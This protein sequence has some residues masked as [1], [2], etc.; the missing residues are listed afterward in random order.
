MNRRILTLATFLAAIPVA[1]QQNSAPAEHT[2]ADIPFRVLGQTQITRGDHKIIMN[3]VAPP[4]LPQRPAVAVQQ[5]PL[6]SPEAVQSALRREKKRA[7]VLF[8]SAT[9]YDHEVTQLRWFGEAGECRA[10]SNIDFNLLSGVN[11]IETDDAVYTIL[12]GLGNESRNAM[13]NRS[14]LFDGTV[15]KVPP[16]SQFNPTRAEYFVMEDKSK[17]ATA[18]SLAGIDALHRY[19]DAN[20]TQLAEDYKKRE[21]ARAEQEA[22]NKAHPPLPR[23]TVIN[24]WPADAR[25]LQEVRTKENQR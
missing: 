18:E 4:V 13:I 2:P 22:W 11:Q 14:Q 16:L 1:A 10:F 24:F 7:E 21:I 23:D 20:R 5:V 25:Q 19:Y 3:R 9:V 12:M 6:P 15:A 8:L 17:P